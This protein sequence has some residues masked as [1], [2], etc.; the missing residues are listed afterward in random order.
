MRRNMHVY[1]FGTVFGWNSHLFVYI[2]DN[3]SR[4]GLGRWDAWGARVWRHS[5]NQLY[6]S[7]HII[8]YQMNS[9]PELR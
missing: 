1:V 6:T 2:S 8:S 3:R 5:I 9:G 4:D 7:H